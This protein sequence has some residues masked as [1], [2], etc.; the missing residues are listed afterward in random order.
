M[1][2]SMM[3]SSTQIAPETTAVAAACSSPGQQQKTD[4]GEHGSKWAVL[5]IVAVGVFM[6]TLDSSIVNISLP[7]IARAFGVPLS[8]TVEWVIIAY[9]VV[10]AGVLLTTG[11][12][13]N[14]I[15]RKP[16]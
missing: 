16:I 11:R 14:M 1:K 7:T 15:G 5:F 2:S 8:G 3:T 6:T 9:L 4:G 13:A 10:V 12:L